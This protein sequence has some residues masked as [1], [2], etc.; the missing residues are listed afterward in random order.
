MKNKLTKYR[1]TVIILALVVLAL[2]IVLICSKVNRPVLPEKTEIEE[3]KEDGYSEA[4]GNITVV[5]LTGTWYEMG[6]QYGR[7]L[8]TQLGEILDFCNNVIDAKLGNAEKAA[9]IVAVQTDQTP[10][11]IQEF[12]RGASETSGLSEEELQTVNAVERILGL[13]TKCSYAAVWGDYAKDTMVIGRNYDYGEIM[14]ALKNDVVV[15]V[16]HP[17]DGSLCTATIGYAG[18]LYAVN[19]L[20][21]AGLFLELNNG[22]ASAPMSSPNERITGTTML[23]E[24]LFKA[25]SFTYL[26][27]YFNTILCSSS[28]I[29]NVADGK[30][31][32]S[33][34]WCPID[35]KH[36]EDTGEEGLLV[37]TNHYNNPEWELE[38]PTDEK[39][40][41]SITRYD[42]LVNLCKAQK[43]NIDA[44]AMQKIV[45]TTLENGG[46]QN[47]LTVYQ[48]VVE[49]GNKMIWVK[50]VESDQWA[51]IDLNKYFIN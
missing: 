50:T 32:R 9:D 43:G 40:W 30:E 37:S 23:W 41:Y 42:N 49:P 22:K 38:Q 19:G 13:P 21:E 35:M 2:G 48:L 15:T 11:T 17:S 47:D 10:Y 18:E 34:E 44:Q 46:A 39:S 51:E 7:L 16:F 31:V 5:N 14:K 8:K 45:T 36:A 4:Y 6:Q 27:R 28:Y 12:F 24:V 33:Y 1:I 29:I 20:N 25:D 3:V 26:D